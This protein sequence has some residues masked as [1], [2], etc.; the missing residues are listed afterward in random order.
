MSGFAA[1]SAAQTPAPVSPPLRSTVQPVGCFPFLVFVL[2][3]VG[4]AGALVMRTDMFL[5]GETAGRTVIE[6]MGSPAPEQ[7]SAHGVRILSEEV[8]MRAFANINATRR[9][10]V[11][12][13]ADVKGPFIMITAYPEGMQT[14]GIDDAAAGIAL[15]RGVAMAYEEDL[16]NVYL[17]ALNRTDQAI[18]AHINVKM[19]ETE[20]ARL[21]WMDVMKKHGVIAEGTPP[22][23]EVM[24]RE[25]AARMAK[26]RLEVA[27]LSQRDVLLREQ[28]IDKVAAAVIAGWSGPRKLISDCQF[29]LRQKANAVA[30]G[31]PAEAATNFQNARKDL[32]AELNDNRNETDTE[33]HALQA[34]ISSLAS[35]AQD[36][37]LAAWNRLNRR[38]E[39]EAAKVIYDAQKSQLNSLREEQMQR[40]VKDSVVQMHTRVIEPAVA[41]ELPARWARK[42]VRYVT[43]G[44][45]VLLGALF[46]GALAWRIRRRA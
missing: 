24:G 6:I 43:Y 33:L 10:G 44:G 5:P 30:A 22:A 21:N 38:S 16:Q 8:Q 14:N 36:L 2:T 1:M 9:P 31:A 41:L 45:G 7:M 18:E 3:L 23:D 35:A 27:L 42:A 26:A 39:T 29:Y 12:V 37:D 34:E 20:K 46:I 32:A 17:G 25:I 13:L 11:K 15:A 19:A 28:D 4:A 40:R